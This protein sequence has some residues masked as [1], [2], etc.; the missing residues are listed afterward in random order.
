MKVRKVLN[1]K[2]SNKIDNT[3]AFIA[4][5][6]SLFNRLSK[7][8][9]MKEI[10]NSVLKVSMELSHID[11]DGKAKMVD[12]AEKSD[13]LRTAKAKAVVLM[14]KDTLEIL[15]SGNAKKGDVLSVAKIAGI[16]AAKKT[17]ELIPLCHNIFL[18]NVDINFSINENGVEISSCASAFSK[19]G[20]EMEALTAASVAALTIYD[21]LK[22]VDKEIVIT[23]VM[24]LYKDGGKSGKF[25]RN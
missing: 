6:K 18:T 25:V 17:A 23:D 3:T 16:M 12:V 10:L 9:K 19:T 4:V 15:M 11:K 22:A 21:M 24:L 20:V 13:T 7:E 8:N 2:I 5:K 14:K 1:E